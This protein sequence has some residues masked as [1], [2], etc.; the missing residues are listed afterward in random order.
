MRIL[1]L[2][3]V[4]DIKV[5]KTLIFSTCIIYL[6]FWI[7]NFHILN[8]NIVCAYY[9]TFDSKYIMYRTP[10]LLRFENL[11]ILLLIEQLWSHNFDVLYVDLVLYV[12]LTFGF[13]SSTVI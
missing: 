5:F 9:Y 11:I 2:F 13:S 12:G 4:F 1:R 10:H 8:L 6:Y 7:E 3:V